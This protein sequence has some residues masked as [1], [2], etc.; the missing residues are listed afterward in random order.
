MEPIFSIPVVFQDGCAADVLADIVAAVDRLDTVTDMIFD[1]V[2]R[3]VQA[4]QEHIARL[5]GRV[6]D[7]KFKIDQVAQQSSN[8]VTVFAPSK[9]PFTERQPN[10]IYQSLLADLRK[11]ELPEEM[12][13]HTDCGL[14][15]YE[16]SEVTESTYP[17]SSA[18]VAE[19]AEAILGCNV[20]PVERGKEEVGLGGLPENLSA[21]SSSVVF[22]TKVNPYEAYEI[23]DNL[24]STDNEVANEKRR[25]EQQ[26]L[27]EKK[28]LS[29][30]PVSI[31]E[32]RY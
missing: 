17:S 28:L 3:R 31:R 11:Q 10:G 27:E 12:E 18:A 8:A 7:C 30:A 1:T 23:V 13:E 32:G 29:E 4:Q 14:R 25:K 20:K 16:P 21:V 19:I 6:E 24:V 9:H 15:R 26:E 5:L 22:N 2:E